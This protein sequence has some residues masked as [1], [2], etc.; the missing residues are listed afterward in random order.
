MPKTSR[1]EALQEELALLRD[2]SSDTVYRVDYSTMR[3][4]YISPNVHALLGYTQEEAKALHVRDLVLETRVKHEG[5][6][7]AEVFKGVELMPHH[8]SVE[9]WV[10]QYLLRAKDGRKIWVTDISH[11][12]RDPQGRL[13]G[14]VGSLRDVSEQ[15]Y[16]EQQLTEAIK[17]IAPADGLT[18]LATRGQCFARL[19]EEM[20]RSKR[21]HTELAVLIMDMDEFEA[22]NAKTSQA[23][24][25]RI[26][27][28]VGRLILG[29]LRET[30]LACRMGGDSFAAILCDSS[31]D[32]AYWVAERI[33]KA[34]EYSEFRLCSS[35]PPVK[36]SISIGLAH[37]SE[38]DTEQAA[39]LIAVAEGRVKRAKK[40]GRNRIEHFHPAMAVDSGMIH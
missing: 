34:V 6:L 26:L 13:V 19:Q 3:F 40:H 20:K 5:A 28:E 27:Q 21:L 22:T 10:A 8:P 31:A 33:R 23:F 11:P 2:Y 1:L 25:D 18:G 32:G 30:D 9:K 16:T 15:V 7:R 35:M 14:S 4:S 24:C 36:V 37:R 38:N 39:S 17:E 12:W 29:N